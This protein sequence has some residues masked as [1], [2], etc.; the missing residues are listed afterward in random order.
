MWLP[1]ELL[2]LL[3][4]WLQFG[5]GSEPGSHDQSHAT[6]EDPPGLALVCGDAVGDV[7][8]GMAVMLKPRSGLGARET[9]EG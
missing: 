4:L 2:F 1:D 8:P 6:G 3:L 5:L 7:T 9:A